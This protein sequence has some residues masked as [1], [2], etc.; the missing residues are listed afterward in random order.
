M[1]IFDK[2]K[3]IKTDSPS[4]KRSAPSVVLQGIEA[5]A[6]LDTVIKSLTALKE[7][8][9]VAVKDAMKER[10]VRIGIEEKRRPVNFKGIEGE[11]SA[12]C[13]LRIRSRTS[14]L[15][16]AEVTFLTKHGI[17]TK[18]VVSTPETF[19]INPAYLQDATVMRAVESALKK[20]KGLPEDFI[21]YQEGVSSTVVDDGALDEMFA[22]ASKE[23][24][25]QIINTIGV[26]AVK[27]KMNEDDFKAAMKIVAKIA[28]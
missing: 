28:K 4:S 14:A 8:K 18:T 5:V 27:P 24:C 11:A 26:L 20:I 6:A 1:A 10:F 25:E 12:S 22:K 19:A 21:Q 13:E 17:T 15:S 23:N 7:T 3:T 2:A 9:M 16:D